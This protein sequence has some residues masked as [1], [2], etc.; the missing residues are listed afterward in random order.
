MKNR[1]IYEGTLI[2]YSIAQD[3]VKSRDF[4]IDNA[5]Y[6]PAGGKDRVQRLGKIPEFGGVLL[7]PTNVD[8]IELLYIDR[9]TP[10]D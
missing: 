3:D 7:N 4:L 8:S 1:D 5:V 6:H 2:R 10:G 9:A